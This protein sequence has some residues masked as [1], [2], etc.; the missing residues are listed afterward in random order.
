MPLAT[1]AQTPRSLGV[2]AGVVGLWPLARVISSPNC[3][4]KK[5]GGI[6]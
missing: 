5:S 1:A 4:L 6:K 3:V 2:P